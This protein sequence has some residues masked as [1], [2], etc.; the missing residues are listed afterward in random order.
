M[1]T[2]NKK[3][4][5]TKLTIET[6]KF[7]GELIF[8]FILSI[9]LGIMFISADMAEHPDMSGYDEDTQPYEIA[10]DIVKDIATA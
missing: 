9:G 8:V 7:I 10:V 6:L 5:L 1:K 2:A 3:S 4:K